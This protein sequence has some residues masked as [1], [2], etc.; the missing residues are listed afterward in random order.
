VTL[1]LV[2]IWTN[3]GH[4]PLAIVIVI[5][6]ILFAGIFSRIIPSQ[7]L[8]S[9][10]P[11]PSK[12]GAFNAISAS[13]QQFA[14]GVSAAIAGLVISQAPTGSLI[15]FDWLGYLVM[16]IAVVTIFLMYF[17]HKQVPEPVIRPS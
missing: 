2:P 17:L 9:A 1:I 3:I 6:V 13:L 4:V 5:N 12:R 7:A 15:H 11:E 10:I 14:G 8:I 16:A